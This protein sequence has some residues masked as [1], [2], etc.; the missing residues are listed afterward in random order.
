MKSV[1]CVY[2]F[3]FGLHCNLLCFFIEL[4]SCIVGKDKVC[5][6]DLHVL[7]VIRILTVRLDPL[8]KVMEPFLEVDQLLVLLVY[9]T[10]ESLVKLYSLNL[11]E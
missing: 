11:I 7:R 10:I 9:S 2:S 6:I 8:T 1:I 3:L 4:V 5:N